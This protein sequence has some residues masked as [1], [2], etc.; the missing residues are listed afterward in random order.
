MFQNNLLMGAA[1][2]STDAAYTVDYSCRFNDDD[3]AYM[4]RTFEAG[5][6]ELFSVS[7]WWKVGNLTDV[8]F[9]NAESGASSRWRYDTSG[10]ALQIYSV[11]DSS[12]VYGNPVFRDPSAWYHV[13]LVWDLSQDSGDRVKWYVNG[14]R[15]TAT[16]STEPTSGSTYVINTAIAHEIGSREGSSIFLD[17]YLSQYCFIDNAAKLPT[18]FGEFNNGVWRPIDITGLDYTGTNSFLLD[19]ADSSNLGNDVSG[20]DHDWATS[21]LDATD[22]VVDTPTNNFCTL[23]SI[24]ETGCNLTATFSEGNLKVTGLADSENKTIYGTMMMPSGKWYWEV[25]WVSGTANEIHVGIIDASTVPGDIGK[26]SNTSYRIYLGAAAYGTLY[27]ND[28]SA[29]AYGGTAF[30]AGDTVCI[31]Y[32]A[33]AGKMWFGRDGTFQGDPAAGSGEAFSSIPQI[34]TRSIQLNIYNVQVLAC[35]FGQLGYA[36]TA[37]TG[38]KALN[39]ANLAEA[40]VKNSKKYFDTILYEGNGTAQKVGQFQPMTETYSVGNSALFVKG[41]STELRQT[42]GATASS[43]KDGT[44]S[45]WLKIGDITGGAGGYVV[46]CG[47]AGGDFIKIEGGL[48]KIQLNNES[49]GQ[50]TSTNKI[51]DTTQWTNLVV[52]YDLDNGEATDRIQIYI[53][54]VNITDDGTFGSTVT[55]AAFEMFQDTIACAFGGKGDGAADY[56]YDGYMAEAVWCDGQVLAPSSFGEV[57]STTNRWIPKDVSGLHLVITVSTLI[58]L[59]RMIWEMMSPVIQMI[60]LNQDLIPQMVPISSTILPPIILP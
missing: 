38:F 1:S 17:G 52:A 22:Q 50:W 24:Q 36:F 26:S 28:S 14:V 42:F 9:L 7:F 34:P 45:M 19:F 20:N 15:I 27:N 55:D 58:L 10:Q 48:I 18:D 33:D 4:Q 23:D 13:L 3:S 12:Y 8:T 44:L 59:M 11:G 57:D 30:S 39:T 43:T 29:G 41:D 47:G 35:D 53:N 60:G 2:I 54:G 5:N 32:D 16:N 6:D 46:T 21:G 49:N 25:K 56:L 37:P 40:T 31:A 51:D